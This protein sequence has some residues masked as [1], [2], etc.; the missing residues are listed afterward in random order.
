MNLIPNDL[1]KFQI[2][3]KWFLIFWNFSNLFG[4]VLNWIPNLLELFQMF[5]KW[6]QD[7]IMWNDMNE[8]DVTW[9]IMNW[10]ENDLNDYAI[11]WRLQNIW[12]P[13]WL[14]FTKVVWW[15]LTKLILWPRDKMISWSKIADHDCTL[16]SYW[17][18][19][20]SYTGEPKTHI[21]NPM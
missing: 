3:W 7:E 6:L 10:F 21:T 4:N 11:S 13:K 18:V 16:N 1:E 12:I 15:W 20:V 17:R 19:K 14:E 2:S 5:W 8:H 9:M